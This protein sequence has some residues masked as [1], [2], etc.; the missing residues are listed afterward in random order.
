[1]REGDREESSEGGK[2]G[3]RKTRGLYNVTY[4]VK[5]GG[6]AGQ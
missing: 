2:E 6:F 3:G 4:I 1:M 5:V